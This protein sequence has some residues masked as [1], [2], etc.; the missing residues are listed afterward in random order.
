MARTSSQAWSD[1]LTD[2]FCTVA[3]NP[4]RLCLPAQLKT[5]A[6]ADERKPA[7][8]G[9]V[10]H[11]QISDWNP[12]DHFSCPAATDANGD[13]RENSKLVTVIISVTL[14]AIGHSARRRRSGAAE[15]SWGYRRPREYNCALL[16]WHPRH[17]RI[18]R[19][20]GNVVS[21]RRCI[22][23][24]NPSGQIARKRDT[25]A[26]KCWLD[27]SRRLFWNFRLRGHA[28]HLG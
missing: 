17:K 15:S 25:T 4:C 12:Q 24:S 20:R 13:D 3:F 16:K 11:S 14:L 23:R 2:F 21:L 27:W 28:D 1:S 6:P 8:F 7:A 22:S 18:M 19:H 10:I 5:A 9:D 26:D